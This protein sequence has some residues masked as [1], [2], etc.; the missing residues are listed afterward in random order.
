MQCY[1]QVI[2]IS[3]EEGFFDQRRSLNIEYRETIGDRREEKTDSF[4]S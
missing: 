2:F 4:E 1:D 3:F